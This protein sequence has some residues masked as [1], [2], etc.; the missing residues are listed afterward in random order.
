MCTFL[1]VCV[2]VCV[3]TRMCVGCLYVRTLSCRYACVVR[4]VCVCVCACL[5]G[6]L[7]PP[8]QLRPKLPSRRLTRETGPRQGS[9]FPLMG[10]VNKQASKSM[11]PFV[12]FLLPSLPPHCDNTAGVAAQGEA[13]FPNSR[14]AQR[15]YFLLV[16]E[17]ENTPLC[18]SPGFQYHRIRKATTLFI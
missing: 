2:C 16:G 14:R 4:C 6:L 3:C 13:A 8:L 15:P 12:V 11:P 18:C 17:W 10:A 5:F 7:T 1:S 9:V